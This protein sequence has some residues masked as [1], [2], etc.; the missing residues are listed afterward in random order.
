MMYSGPIDTLVHLGAILFGVGFLVQAGLV[1]RQNIM[2]T[3]PEADQIRDVISG[4]TVAIEG[5]VQAI[6]NGRGGLQTTTAPLS[7]DDCVFS[8]WRVE[9]FYGHELGTHSGW[10]EQASGYDAEVFELS[11]GSGTIAVN[12]SSDWGFLDTEFDLEGLDSPRQTVTIDD[13][14]PSE[15][16]EFESAIG[17]EKRTPAIIDVP[18]SDSGPKQ[19]DRRYY[20]ATISPGDAVFISGVASERD[21]DTG[22][23]VTDGGDNQLLISD[24]G[25]NSATRDRLFGVVVLSVVSICLLWYG[26]TPLL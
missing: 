26:V 11:D 8:A 5:T 17:I 6:Q 10:T 22:L 4:D 20:E 16:R 25:R 23:V 9:E 21:A 14:L 7:G 2:M 1:L 15:I 24:E 3:S 18:T 13:D 12:I 19:G